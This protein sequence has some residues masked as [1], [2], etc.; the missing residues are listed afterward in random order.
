MEPKSPDQAASPIIQ[1]YSELSS[2]ISYLEDIII[3][4]GDK[5]EPV[6]NVYPIVAGDKEKDP[7]SRSSYRRMIDEASERVKTARITLENYITEIEI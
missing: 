6:R 2:Q 4:L 7:L 5:L 3:N 1:A